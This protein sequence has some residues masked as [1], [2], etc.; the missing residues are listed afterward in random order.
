MVNPPYYEAASAWLE[1]AD[2]DLRS[3]ELLL[4]AEP[5]E[6]D[7]AAFHCQQA[8][9]KYLKAIMVYHGKNP[10]K[11]HDLEQLLDDLEYYTEDTEQLREPAKILTP[12]AVQ[13]RYPFHGSSP[14]ENDARRAL[15]MAQRVG[16]FANTIVKPG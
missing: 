15:Q 13:L 10:P 6:L 3:A 8:G 9:E 5:P 14:S 16:S 4:S 1:K 2:G 7:A 11:T 12:F